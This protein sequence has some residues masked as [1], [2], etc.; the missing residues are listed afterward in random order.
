MCSLAG[1]CGEPPDHGPEPRADGLD[2]AA[3]RPVRCDARES[4]Q[5][6]VARHADVVQPYLRSHDSCQARSSM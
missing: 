4:V 2:G 5:Q 3:V 1:T 6:V